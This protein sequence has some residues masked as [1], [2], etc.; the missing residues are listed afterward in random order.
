MT[1]VCPVISL[2]FRCQFEI[3]SVAVFEL[4]FPFPLLEVILMSFRHFRGQ[5]SLLDNNT[6]VLLS[7]IAPINKQKQSLRNHFSSLYLVVS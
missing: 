7:S 1:E 5:S 2:V 3:M 4:Y 6:G